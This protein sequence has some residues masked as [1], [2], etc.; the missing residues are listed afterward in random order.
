MDKEEILKLWVESSMAN[1][2][3]SNML[4]DSGLTIIFVDDLREDKYYVKLNDNIKEEIS[5]EL[6]LKYKIST[7]EI[8]IKFTTIKNPDV[9]FKIVVLDS[10]NDSVLH[11]QLRA[12]LAANE[13]KELPGALLKRMW[14][15][16]SENIDG[17][18]TG[19]LRPAGII[20]NHLAEG[21]CKTGTLE[22]L[23]FSIDDNAP[24]FRAY[25]YFDYKSEHYVFHSNENTFGS[26]ETIK[27][28]FEAPL[29]SGGHIGGLETEAFNIVLM[30]L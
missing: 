25:R 27:S 29:R 7:N 15:T 1:L 28:A 8:P 24:M 3:V 11:K 13:V 19:H 10:N 2:E 18:G 6:Y 30:T 22:F 5:K 17:N 16:L 20:E 23:G 12:I 14:V 9:I 4:K 26:L 21:Y